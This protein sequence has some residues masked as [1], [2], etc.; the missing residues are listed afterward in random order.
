MGKKSRAKKQRAELGLTG[1][2]LKDMKRKSHVTAFSDPD[3]NMVCFNPMKKLVNG[4]IYK[5]ETGLSVLNYTVQQYAA[6][7]QQQREK[8]V[9]ATKENKEGEE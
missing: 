5:D 1:K 6:Y 8:T 3:G 2:Q 4:E 9:E 7:M